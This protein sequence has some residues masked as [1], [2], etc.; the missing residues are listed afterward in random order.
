MK[1][2]AEKCYTAQIPQIYQTTGVP[3]DLLV[4]ITNQIDLEKSNLEA[5]SIACLISNVALNRPIVAQMNISPDYIITDSYY[6]GHLF[7]TLLHEMIH[8]LGMNPSM[9]GYF[10]YSNGS[11]IGLNNV[12]Q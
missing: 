6:W 5:W 4:L 3:A 2:T 9:F 7:D 8:I 1:I 12:I 10:V 11:T